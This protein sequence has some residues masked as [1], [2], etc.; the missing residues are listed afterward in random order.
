MEVLD[1]MLAEQ[2]AKQRGAPQSAI[3]FNHVECYRIRE[4]EAATDT[5]DPFGV[6][7]VPVDS[8]KKSHVRRFMTCIASDGMD[9]AG[10]DFVGWEHVSVCVHVYRG[11]VKVRIETPTWDMMS[12]IRDLFWPPGACVVQFHPP[13]DDYVNVHPHVL[14]LWRSIREPFP[15]PPKVCV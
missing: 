7:I 6:F 8:E 2:K 3:R 5:G 1:R 9:G 11:K 15:M 12:T 10:Q 4:G 13:H 14:H